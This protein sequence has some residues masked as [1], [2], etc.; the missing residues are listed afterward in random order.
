MTNIDSLILISTQTI[1]L[2]NFRPVYYFHNSKMPNDSAVYVTCKKVMSLKVLKA[3]LI[4]NLLL[5][6]YMPKI[7]IL[8][9]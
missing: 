8:S 2:T 6:L 1:H 3:I 4:V 5:I 7:G 9:S